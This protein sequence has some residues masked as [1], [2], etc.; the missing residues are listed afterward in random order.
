MSSETSRERKDKSGET[1]LKKWKD[2]FVIP[3]GLNT[4]KDKDI[5]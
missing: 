4:V 3:H 1:P 2:C 5:T